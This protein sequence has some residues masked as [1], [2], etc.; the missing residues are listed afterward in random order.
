VQAIVERGKLPD[1]PIAPLDC[2]LPF[3]ERWRFVLIQP[4]TG[5]GLSG[6]S[7]QQAFSQL[8]PVPDEVT[9]KLRE[10]IRN[11]IVPAVANGEFDRF[12]R[13]VYRYGRLAGSCFAAVQGGPY[14][15][16]HLADLVELV[17]S[18]GSAGVGQSSRGPTLFVTVADQTQ[19]A[20]LVERLQK[21]PMAAGAQL[22]VCGA[23]N[24]G[25]RVRYHETG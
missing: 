11:D 22:S 7:E 1:E 19:A 4:Q 21:E 2:R 6:S 16:T 5:R 23:D 3:P 20:N 17:R 25:A 18:L 10:E 9:A 8:P 14:N 24:C 12:S 13:S 15:G